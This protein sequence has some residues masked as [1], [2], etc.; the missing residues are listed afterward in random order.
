MRSARRPACLEA[1]PATLTVTQAL[2]DDLLARRR[3]LG[4]LR[5]RSNEIDRELDR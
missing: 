3:Y 5:R 4:D 1:F 2:V